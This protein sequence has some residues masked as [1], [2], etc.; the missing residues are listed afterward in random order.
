MGP[1][2]FRLAEGDAAP[3]ATTPGNV[4]SEGEVGFVDQE[5]FEPEEE[6]EEEGPP[7]DM[8]EELVTKKILMFERTIRT[9]LGLGY[10]D[11][12]HNGKQDKG[13]RFPE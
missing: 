8:R 1:G 13:I 5:L 4:D 2:N 12:K 3:K 10:G 6:T 9:I 11:Y 7:V